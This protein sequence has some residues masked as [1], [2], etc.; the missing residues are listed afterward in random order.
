MVSRV[1]DTPVIVIPSRASLWWQGWRRFADNKVAVVGL[2]WLVWLAVVAIWGRELAPYPLQYANLFAGNEGP[3]LSHPFGTDSLGQDMLTMVMYGLRY[4]L[5]VGFGA[6]AVS[7]VVGVVIGLA[8]GM[9]GRWVD[10]VLMRLTDFMYAFPGFLFSAFIASLFHGRMSAVI[11]VFGLTQWAGFARLTRG[12]V[13]TVR[14][15]ELVESGHAIGASTVFI[16][17][18]YILPQ[19]IN[20]IIVYTAFVAVNI[21]TLQAELSLFYGTGPALPLISFAQLISQGTVDVL[22]YWWLLVMPVATL[23]SLL[24]ALVVVGE[25]L[26]AALNPKGTRIL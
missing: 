17:F 5:A 1:A 24:V 11:A 14:H 19:V 9:S 8:S 13:L 10:E 3:S 22:G 20:S 12:L 25:G 7:L 15:S 23:I 18:R 6:T 2:G 21:I 26:Q 4:T 16:A